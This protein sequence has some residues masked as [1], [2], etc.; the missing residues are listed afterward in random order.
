MEYGQLVEVRWHTALQLGGSCWGMHTSMSSR[1]GL[2]DG[3]TKS[4]RAPKALQGVSEEA[5][6]YSGKKLSV[7]SI[8]SFSQLSVHRPCIATYDTAAGI[9]CPA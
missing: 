5:V 2:A 3:D 8:E 9:S 7:K 1:L 4:R 6:R